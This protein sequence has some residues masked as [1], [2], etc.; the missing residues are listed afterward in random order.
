MIGKLFEDWEQQIL[1]PIVVTVLTAGILVAG[2]LAFSPIRHFFF[3][4]ADVDDYPL[5]C[6]AEAYPTKYQ[7]EEALGVDFFL[8][9]LS[10]DEQSGD[11]LQS[12]LLES[13]RDSTVTPSTRITLEYN[14]SLGR[15]AAASYR[16]D[17]FN[18]GKGELEVETAGNTIR[19]VPR[20]LAARAI[21]KV[22]I[23]I[24]DVIT[25]S[26]ISRGAQAAVPFDDI[27][28]YQR[29]CYTRDW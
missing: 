11:E 21:I 6:T 25:V 24:A 5:Y 26:G 3:P 13:N 1:R 29:G 28:T 15:V 4:P 12:I 22:S 20:H 8:I 23:V 16:D 7:G 14:R 17:A 2:S 19:I 18:E 27:A 10:G 9:N